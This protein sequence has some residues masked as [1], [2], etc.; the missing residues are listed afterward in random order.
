MGRAGGKR[1]GTSIKPGP[2]LCAQEGALFVDAFAVAAA[3]V[4]GI[5]RLMPCVFQ[6]RLHLYEVALAF[7]LAYLHICTLAYL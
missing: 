5:L 1:A 6:M 7:V 3:I 4:A 2:S